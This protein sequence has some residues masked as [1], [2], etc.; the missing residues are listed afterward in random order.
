MHLKEV[1]LI[2]KREIMKVKFMGGRNRD[3]FKTLVE[4]NGVHFN[5]LRTVSRN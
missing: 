5:R 1:F 3:R 4:S 2:L